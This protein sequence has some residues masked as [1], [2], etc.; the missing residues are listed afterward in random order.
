MNSKNKI[1]MF[2]KKK[3]YFFFRYLRGL[4]KEVLWFIKIG[5]LMELPRVERMIFKELQEC[6]IQRPSHT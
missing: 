4:G 2:E 6:L 3:L 1:A 5:W